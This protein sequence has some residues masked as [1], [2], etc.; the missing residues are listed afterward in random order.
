[1]AAKKGRVRFPVDR[2]QVDRRVWKQA[3]LLAGKDNRRI[4]VI[5]ETEVIVHNNPRSTR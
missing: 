5:S 4:E 1:M 2:K 3:R